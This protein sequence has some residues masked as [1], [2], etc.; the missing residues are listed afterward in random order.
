[1][2]PITKINIA[3]TNQV[4]IAV[5]PD[6]ATA[7]LKTVFAATAPALRRIAV[8]NSAFDSYEW[9]AGIMGRLDAKGK[10]QLREAYRVHMSL[11][12][13]YGAGTL[14]DDAIASRDMEELLEIQTML[15]TQRLRALGPHNAELMLHLKKWLGGSMVC[16]PHN[17]CTVLGIDHRRVVHGRMPKKTDERFSREN[18]Y[19]TLFAVSR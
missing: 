18:Q 3:Q 19:A 14:R 11:M 12:K 10:E 17:T 4:N 15:D 6:I 13:M 1:M 16:V 8:F 5:T 9:N 2:T 7:V